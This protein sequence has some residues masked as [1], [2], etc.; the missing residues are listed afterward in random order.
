AI[1]ITAFALYPIVQGLIVSLNSVNFATLETSF[2]G[3]DNYA[4]VLQDG[5][6]WD[7]AWRTI[8]YVLITNFFTL[9]IGMAISLLLHQELVG[10]NIARGLVLFPYLVPA[11]VIALTWRFMLD[12]TLGVLNAWLVDW[13]I[14]DR[15][16]AFLTRPQTAMFVVIFASIWKYTPFMIIMFLA[17]LQVIPLELEEAAKLDGAS[18]WQI[19]WKITIPWMLPVIIIALLLRTIW[20][21]NEF[22][23]VYLFNFGGPLSA[24]TTLPVYVR[25]LASE[26]RNL[27][28]AAAA[29]TLMLGLLLVMAWGYFKLYA[30]AEQELY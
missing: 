14:I 13:N 22:E 2:I 6:F 3:I 19:F 30:R 15:P 29:A 28:Q 10:R 7:S 8:W 5:D 27:G 16:I 11:I 24:T 26:A 1:L 21:F 17:R 23:M 25:D 18:S 9:I 12:P 20:T 4:A